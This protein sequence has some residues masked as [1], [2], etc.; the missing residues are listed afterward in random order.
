MRMSAIRKLLADS[1]LSARRFARLVL[2]ARGE[3][4]MRRW[5]ADG[6]PAELE[7]WAEKDVVRL[8][9][10]GHMLHLTIHAPVDPRRDRKAAG[11]EDSE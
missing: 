7:E 6:F 10:R 4:S 3:R 2:A 9:R 8:E 5:E 1:G 11:A